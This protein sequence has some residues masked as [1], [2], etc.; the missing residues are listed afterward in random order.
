VKLCRIAAV[1]LS[2]VHARILREILTVLGVEPDASRLHFDRDT[3]GGPTVSGR[4]SRRDP[5]ASPGRGGSGVR[6]ISTRRHV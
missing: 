2:P 4:C 5:V 6:T 3:G 1:L